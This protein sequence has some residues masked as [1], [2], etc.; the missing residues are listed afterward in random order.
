[1]A[2]TPSNRPKLT[3]TNSPFLPKALKSPLRGRTS[4]DSSL[5][6]SR[7]SLQR[8]AGTT[9]TSATGFDCVQSSF[10]YI[11][12]GAAVVVDVD[13]EPAPHS[14]SYTY[15]QRFYRARP[16]AVPLYSVSNQTSNSPATPASTPKAN[17]SRNRVSSGLFRECSFGSEYAE[18]KTWTSRER[19]KAASCLALSR[20][21]RFL[22]VGEAGYAPRVLIFGLQDSSSDVPLVSISEHSFGVRA[23]AW[24]QDTRFLASLGTVNDGFLYMWK[25]DPRTGA[26]KLFQ[27]NRC[28][29]AIKDI[30]WMGTNLITLGVRHVKAWKVEENVAPLPIKTKFNGEPPLTPLQPQKTLPGR[31]VLLGS[32]IDSTFTC[33]A[34]VDDSRTIICSEA[35]DV[36]LLEDDGKQMKLQRVLRL[37]FC[38]SSITIRDLTAY[39]SGKAGQFVTLDVA[40]VVDFCEDSVLESNQAPNG[41]VAMGFIRNNFVTIDFGRSI[42]IWNRDYMPGQ[43]QDDPSHIL[44]PGHDEAIVGVQ[45]LQRP[46]LHNADFI[47]WSGSGKMIQWDMDGD[48]KSTYDVPIANIT[49]A[50]EAEPVNQLTVM[51][52][53]KLGDLIVAGDRVG[54]LKV[55]DLHTR[56]CLL[57]TKAHSS[58]VQDI[59]VFEKANSK[60]LII[61]TCGRDRTVQLFHR[62][63]S[64]VLRHFQTL[65]FAAKVVQVLIPSEDRILTCSLDRTLQVHDVVSRTTDAEDLAAVPTRAVALKASPTSMIMSNDPKSQQIFVSLL[66]RS[67]CQYDLSTSRLLHSFKCLD[68]SGVESAVL[69]RLLLD[70]TG[71]DSDRLLGV[72]NTDKSVRMY[73]AQTGSFLGREW[74]HTEAINGLALIETD[75]CDLKAATVASDGTL[76]LWSVIGQDSSASS[77]SRESSP[78]KDSGSAHRTPLRRVLSKAELAEYQK[79]TIAS[80]GRRSP[81]RSLNRRA[82]RQFLSASNNVPKTPQSQ[83]SSSDAI[84]DSPC[85]KSVSPGREASPPSPRRRV[86]HRPSLPSLTSSSRKKSNSNLKAS[87]NSN[88]NL[89]TAT[90][91]A[92]RTLRAYRKKLTSTEPI[93][94]STLEELDQELRLTVSALSNRAIRSRAVDES[95]LSGLLDEYSE[96]LVSMLDEKLRLSF[97][98]LEE[99]G[100]DRDR[101]RDRDR[102]CDRSRGRGG[103]DESRSMERPRAVSGDSTSTLT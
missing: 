57:D 80:S 28:T 69:E 41:I 98:Q 12:G 62:T 92:C 23:V 21:G 86:H 65:E 14:F 89:N 43:M 20:D 46:N 72:S 4:T 45:T 59:T 49:P 60:K 8:V 68:E 19:I 51:K 13:H 26:A 37:D 96:R 99:R 22:A 40:K 34:V 83:S 36:C 77:T 64:G 15:S 47:T 97:P 100:R 52:A 94:Q 70:Q 50:S 67:V 90:E 27:Q 9:C 87:G 3:T 16:T 73:D 84:S 48:I 66:D 10:A 44:I 58:E 82:S 53:T 54:V 29:S 103:F 7:I 63:S 56:K 95:M 1:M 31:N 30:V 79:P 32:M 18:S 5:S 74:G 71:R 55:I 33:A 85:K 25:I 75:D 35:G 42:E 93:S 11:A 38:I 81:P 91:Q 61:A 88:S 24:S 78:A 2:S 17:D 101:V 6:Q 39:V 76:M 102:D